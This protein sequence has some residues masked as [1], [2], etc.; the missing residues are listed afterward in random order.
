MTKTCTSTLQNYNILV[1]LQTRMPKQTGPCWIHDPII[2]TDAHGRVAPIHLELV[3]T[4]DIFEAVLAARFSG[5]PGR[6]KVERRE[7]VL[8]E[9]YLTTD[10]ERSQPFESC[11]MPGRTVDMSVSF[12]RRGTGNACP[13]CSLETTVAMSTSTQW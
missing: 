12:K 3:N 6:G 11:F 10:I 13:K 5:L 1:D 9:R 2:F 4:W 7:Y 8:Q